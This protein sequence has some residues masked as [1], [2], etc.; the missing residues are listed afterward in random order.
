[1]QSGA[2]GRYSINPES[3][4]HG[5]VALIASAELPLGAAT[6][7]K[8]ASFKSLLFNIITVPVKTF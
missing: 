2:A 3:K 1:M 7:G 6:F 8:P 5:R 4:W